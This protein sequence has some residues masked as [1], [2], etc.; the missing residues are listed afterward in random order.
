MKKKKIAIV[1]DHAG[2]YLKEKLLKYLIKEKF[3]VKT[4]QTGDYK[5]RSKMVVDLI[6]SNHYIGRPFSDV[7][8]D[9]GNHDGYFENDAIP[10]YILTEK[11]NKVVWQLVFI[12]DDKWEKVRSVEIRKN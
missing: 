8:K 5:I 11:T 9:L 4:F 10:A 6:S 12:P 3:D 7:K 1:S 2:F